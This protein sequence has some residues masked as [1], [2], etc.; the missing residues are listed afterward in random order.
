MIFQQSVKF[1]DYNIGLLF[2]I[3][4]L[5]KKILGWGQCYLRQALQCVLGTSIIVSSSISLSHM[6]VGTKLSGTYF[7]CFKTYTIEI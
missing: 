5:K 2:Y 7:P 4:K 1:Y 6:Y 3:C